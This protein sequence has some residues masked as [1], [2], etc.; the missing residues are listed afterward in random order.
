MHN[1]NKI[2]FLLLIFIL[3]LSLSGCTELFS[4]DRNIRYKNLETKIS[5]DIAYGVRVNCSGFGDFSIKY[6]CDTPDL[7]IGSINDILVLNDEYE[8]LENQ[9]TFNDLKH[10]N[11]SKTDDCNPYELGVSASIIS[12]S[13]NFNDL[14]GKSAL[15]I[16][17]ISKYHQDK[18]KKYCKKQGNETIV[19]IDPDDADINKV[20]QE[21]LNDANTNN[22][23]LIAKELFSW[24][25][26]NTQY[27]QHNE[28]NNVQ[29]AYYTLEEKTGD[30]DDLTY[31]Y[32]SLCRSLDIPARFIRGFLVNKNTAI[33][34]AWAEV[35]V[36][37]S[38]NDGWIPVECAGG[39]NDYEVKA[40]IHQNFA[41]ESAE[42]LRLFIDDGSNESLEISHTG[43]VYSS[44]S[45][46]D[47]DTPKFFADV[48][49]Y[50]V[51]S[52]ND[53]VI[54]KNDIRSIS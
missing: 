38:E 10:W 45:R 3:I 29:P 53:L 2:L 40:E 15:T 22:S 16:D 42:H 44:D 50:Q 5:F 17:E 18:V 47:F 25:K 19:Y 46:V 30:C 11:I 23:F 48:T 28:D 13:Y 9:A 26:T 41:F 1:N 43:I 6:S 36:G 39:S 35:F 4:P 8:D 33:A 37:I 34:H 20:S 12:E 51:L 24:L 32:L 52:N 54:N 21:V 31:L 7:L 14:N 49:N 27:M